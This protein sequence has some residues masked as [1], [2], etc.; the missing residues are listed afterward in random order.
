M[1]QS[2]TL[3]PPELEPPV[4]SRRGGLWIPMVIGSAML[5][6]TM[7][8][9]MLI[10][11]LP[12]LADA[13]T[14]DPL[15]LN[16]AITLYLLASAVF[17]PIS[18]WAADRWGARRVFLAAIALFAA[19]SALCGMAQN[20]AQLICSRFLQG[21]AAALMMPAGRIVLL[22]T[23]PRTRIVD[24]LA[25]M[26][27]PAV[28]G[29]MTG[30][31]VGGFIVTYWQWRWI[32]FINLP[33][34][35]LVLLLTWHLVPRVKAYE[36]HGFDWI[37]LCLTGIGLGSL[38]LGFE[39]VALESVSAVLC[40]AAIATSL[41]ALWIYG[42]Y[43]RGKPGAILDLT[44]FRIRT[45]RSATLG[46][47]VARLAAMSMPFLL[48]I[49]LQVGWGRSAW[50]AG[51]LT[52]LTAAGALVIRPLAARV[53]R[54]FGFRRV[55]VTTCILAAG[56]TVLFGFY[57][58][59][60]PYAVII[61]VLVTSGIV[62]SLQLT[63]FATLALADIEE[64]DL[65][66]AST[67]SSLAMQSVQSISIGAAAMLLGLLVR[68]HGATG[69]TVETIAPAFWILGGISL[70]AVLFPARLPRDAGASLHG[71]R[72]DDVAIPVTSPSRSG[73]STATD[74]AL[75]RSGN[76]KVEGQ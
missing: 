66:R 21:I 46:V 52:S 4:P 13:F 29:S 54:R 12:A 60:V 72:G 20:M 67:W 75:S 1:R 37:G 27:I 31:A 57:R 18:G 22:R 56:F 55:L 16:L 50:E 62:R 74:S 19:S 32:F 17:L 8:G 42:R 65:A 25:M 2:Q 45:F 28:I 9:M 5:M 44:L 15:R 58:P 30:P 68:V 10:T 49:W 61:A 64:R 7:N 40:A 39:L 41:I 76:F 53:L 23:T 33:F 34:A 48:A 47:S 24:A 38:I 69:P 26:M 71:P 6:Q 14:V 70:L 35:A 3:P 63:A 36:V 59:G 73:G 51:I 43:A 11:A